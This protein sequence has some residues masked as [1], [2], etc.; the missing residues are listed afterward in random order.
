MGHII[1]GGMHLPPLP[2]AHCSYIPGAEDPF[3]TC[4]D[5][6]GC[7][8]ALLQNPETKTGQLSSTASAI[9]IGIRGFLTFTHRLGWPRALEL[10]DRDE[11]L[12]HELLHDTQMGNVNSS[13]HS[14]TP[15]S[16]VLPCTVATA[17][18]LGRQ[19]QALCR[20]VWGFCG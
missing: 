13:N 17:K 14:L 16:K 20:C 18:D 6:D 11:T 12:D 5:D 4:I 1:P 15:L 7:S 2:P 19:F 3:T 10:D 9:G 8:T